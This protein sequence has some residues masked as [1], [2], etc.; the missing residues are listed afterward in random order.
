MGDVVERQRTHFGS[1]SPYNSTKSHLPNGEMLC[2]WVCFPSC[3]YCVSPVLR[4]DS[5]VPSSPPRCGGRDRPGRGDHLCCP[6]GPTAHHH[7]GEGKEH[8]AAEPTFQLIWFL[9]G[10]KGTL[11]FLKLRALQCTFLFSLALLSKQVT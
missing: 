8:C 1:E 3:I 11:L 9:K 5:C 6:G 10:F 2:T 4:S 7:L